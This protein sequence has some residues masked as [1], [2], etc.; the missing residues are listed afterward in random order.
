ML[1]PE[2]RH[3]GPE[4]PDHRNLLGDISQPGSDPPQ[5]VGQAAGA[6]LEERFEQQFLLMDFAYG[7]GG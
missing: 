6:R 5:T 4:L 3:G 2:D 7:T 1:R